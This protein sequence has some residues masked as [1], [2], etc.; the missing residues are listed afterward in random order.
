MCMATAYLK[1]G[2]ATEVFL[3]EVAD[4][5]LRG[6][7]VQLRPLLGEPKQVRATIREIDF[8]NSTIVLEA[9]ES[10]RKR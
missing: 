1:H 7:S 9:L 8:L 5:Q 6:N 4:V 2:S 10:E 3:E